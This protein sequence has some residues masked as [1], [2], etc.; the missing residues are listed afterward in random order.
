M[1]VLFAAN[2]L[3]LIGLA[4]YFPW[5]VP[6]LLALG[7]APLSPVSYAL[8]ALTAVLGVAV[9]LWWWNTADQTR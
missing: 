7:Q 8:V 5:G 9:T 3:A 4:G 6:G 2:I 1:L